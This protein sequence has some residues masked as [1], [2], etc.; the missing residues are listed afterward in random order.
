MKTGKRKFHMPGRK[1]RTQNQSEELKTNDPQMFSLRYRSGLIVFR[2]AQY[3]N[4]GL[5][6]MGGLNCAL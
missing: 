6:K 2:E 4:S 5:R 1:E 3:R